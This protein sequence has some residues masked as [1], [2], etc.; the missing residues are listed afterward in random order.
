MGLSTSGC[1]TMRGAMSKVPGFR[2]CQ[3]QDVKQIVEQDSLPLSTIS[4]AQ[5][6][7]EAINHY[8]VTSSFWGV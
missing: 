2:S 5:L 8:Y 1:G 6:K 3:F 4:M 7:P